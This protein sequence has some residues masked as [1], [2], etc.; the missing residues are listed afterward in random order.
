MQTYNQF[1]Q[2]NTMPLL[3]NFTTP[4]SIQ[5]NGF[6]LPPMGYN[7]VTQTSYEMR[8]LATRSA[9]HR[10][11]TAGPKGQNSDWKNENDDVKTV[12]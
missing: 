12:R 9:K 10:P 2:G 5:E 1:N 7:D 8:M 4:N 6:D 3:M 11:R